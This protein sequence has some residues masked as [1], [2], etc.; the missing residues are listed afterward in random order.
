METGEFTFAHK[1]FV[2]LNEMAAL[3]QLLQNSIETGKIETA[4]FYELVHH[5]RDHDAAMKQKTEA[6]EIALL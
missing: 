4:L 5:E 1:V 3:T 2:L 6:Q